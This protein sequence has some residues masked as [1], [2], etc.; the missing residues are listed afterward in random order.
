G[1]QSGDGSSGGKVGEN[2]NPVHPGGNSHNEDDSNSPD[3]DDP[4]IANTDASPKW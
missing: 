1:R 3:S 4:D 2:G